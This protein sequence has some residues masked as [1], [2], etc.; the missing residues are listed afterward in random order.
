MI[1]KLSSF[2][3]QQAVDSTVPALA[4]RSVIM[5]LPRP[6][7]GLASTP[8]VQAAY[9][10]ISRV[11]IPRLIG[12]GRNTKTPKNSNDLLPALKEGLLQNEIE[13]N[14]EDIDVLIEVVRCFGPLLEQVEVEAMQ[15]VVMGLLQSTKVTS[16][17]KK[18]AVVAVAMLAIY[19]NE[20][21]LE[22]VIGRLT[23]G[24]DSSATNAVTRR[25]YISILGSMAR[26][27]PSR[28][29]PYIS[30]AAPRVL[31]ALAEDELSL[32][33]EKMNDGDDV[34]QDFN[35]IR[36]A[37]LV[38][39]EAFVASCPAEMRPFIG[40]VIASCLRYLKYDPNYAVDDDDDDMDD[41]GSED[42]D[43]DEE[44]EEDDGF[45]DDD[46]DA[47]WKV[48]RCAAKTLFSLVASR[49]GEDLL[50][51][52]VLYAQ[53][54]P[55]LIKRLDEREENVRLEVISSLSA[56]IRK[57]G[58]GLH[59][60]D[61][62]NA[63]T[64]PDTTYHAPISRKRRRQSSVGNSTT[65]TAG[66]TSPTLEKLPLSGPR[67][68]LARLT[69]NI[70]K[71]AKK[72]LQGKSVSTK[73]A[74]LALLDD[75]VS[76]Q[77]GGL[78]DFLPEIVVSIVEA[79]KASGSGGGHTSIANSGSGS[80][81]ATPSTLRVVALGLVSDISRTHSSQVLQPYLSV[82]VDSVI[83]A[84]HDKFYKISSEG[85]L[86]A[87]EL[88]KTI[89][90]P[91][92]RNTGAK[93][94]D[95][96]ERLY[97]AIMDRGLANDTDAEVR[98]RAIHAL[99]VLLSRTMT[100]DGAQL[101][102]EARRKQSLDV[103]RERL[104]NETTR[105]ASVRAIDSVAAFAT[106]VGQLEKSWIQDVAVELAAQL[107]KANR[108]LRGSSVMALKH[109][110]LSPATKGQLAPSNIES[111]VSALMPAVSSADTQLLGPAL[112]MF[113]NFVTDHPD[114]VMTPAMI[115]ALCELL[116]GPFASI[117]LEP[118]LD[119]V[120]CAGKTGS[121]DALMHGLLQEVSVQGD[122]SVVG[123]VIGTLLVTNKSSGNVS[124]QSFVSELQ[125]S[126]ES[127]D[128][129]RTCLALAVLGEA[130]MRLAGDASADLRP[131]TFLDQFHAEPDKVSLSAAIALGR[132]GSGD[133]QSYIPVILKLMQEGG[134]KQYLLI[135]SIKEILQ[136]L[137]SLTA[138]I[139]PHAEQIWMELLQA[140]DHGDNRVVCA[141]CVGRLATLAPKIFIPKLQ[142]RPRYDTGLIRG[143]G[144]LIF[145]GF[146]K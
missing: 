142:V 104:L 56:L 26:S 20:K 105:L 111:I 136:S 51:D 23:S 128:D 60:H 87:E 80:A 103:L 12:P 82:L 71:A 141:E 36:E 100:D 45:E 28:F 124:V 114:I 62:A 79:I 22:E 19:L 13:L 74:I 58:D 33:L 112:L 69:P 134:N 78:A 83:T 21:N 54:A 77:R 41:G 81:S 107:R 76:V 11:L 24:L 139:E 4:L 65:T 138:E 17:V 125:T 89:T 132:A 109:L 46:D 14:A 2:K 91:R 72:Q 108:S 52:G 57:A 38:T 102:T 99:G 39:I 127:G 118:L 70:V 68:D 95:D 110:T 48:R 44:F 49:S 7:P 98:Q 131:Q 93:H 135:Q 117:V 53:A 113:A 32:H 119:F 42:N 106:T 63:D 90:P 140:S 9:S 67:A 86:T 61:L 92:S 116:K 75:I 27:I 143:H 97:T 121:A 5:A 122:P 130:A 18:R 50:Q 66:L 43:D 30:S 123:R 115:S 47:S 133:V 15:E 137:A 40:E 3:L 101:L 34:G 1:E 96:L 126:S 146:A 64:E 120:S 35:E 144:R 73:Q 94:Q 37:A 85:I 6:V 55:A 145:P 16:V 88:I 129:D 8:E 59:L 31:R 84:I 25:L 29:G 10:A